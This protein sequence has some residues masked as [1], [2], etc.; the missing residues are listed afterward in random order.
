MEQDHLAAMLPTNG[1]GP[2]TSSAS[3]LL[4]KK[5]PPATTTPRVDLER[6]LPTIMNDLVPL[7]VIV[8]RVVSQAYADLANLAETLPSSPD[9]DR[10]RAIVDYV[11]QT[12]RQILK[13]LVLVRWSG[14]ASNVGK[15]MNIIGFLGRQNF[16]FDS[17][18]ASLTDAKSSLSS[19]R[20]RNYDIPTA[21]SVLTSGTY[22]RLPGV[23]E[24]E[25]GR[26]K[27]L[28]DEE[29]LKVLGETDEVLRWRLGVK[30]VLPRGMRDYWIAD[31]RATFVVSGVW[32]ASFTYASNTTSQVSTDDEEEGEWF[33]LSLRFLFKV[34]DARGKRLALSYQLEALHS[35]AQVLAATTWASALKVEWAIDG[36]NSGK[37]E[38]RIA[39]WLAFEACLGGTGEEVQRKLDVS[40]SAE[41]LDEPEKKRVKLDFLYHQLLNE[42]KS[43]DVE[44]INESSIEGGE[45]VAD[46]TPTDTGDIT[47][48]VKVPSIRV[49][50]FGQHQ[51]IA[52]VSSLSG[53]LE[54]KAVGEVAAMREAR[55]RNAAEKVDKDRKIAGETLLRVRAS[56]IVDEV[57]SRAAYLGFRTVRRLSLRSHDLAKFGMGTR[58]FLFIHLPNLSTHYLVLVLQE[59][60]FR[61]ALI[62]VSEV[63]DGMQ[64]WLRVD[65]L[66]W[67]DKSTS[68]GDWGA[69]ASP[70]SPAGEKPAAFGHDVSIEDLR[71]VHQYCVRRIAFFKLE[72]QLHVRR[73]PFKAVSSAPA[74]APADSTLAKRSSSPSFTQP[75]L[76]SRSSPYLVIQSTDLLRS[77]AKVA[78]PNIAIQCFQTDDDQL[79]TTIH[80]RFKDLALVNPD[81]AELPSSM[82]YDPRTS[83]ITFTSN[84]ID[85][86]I[87]NFLTAYSVV[88][89]SIVLAQH[90]AAEAGKGKKEEKEE[91]GM[92]G[93]AVIP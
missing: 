13:L 59:E 52:S 25:F 43:E 33:L 38:V 18:I 16:A 7:S 80:V 60:G 4:V 87:P 14:E 72:Q 41:G 58:S 29:A 12:R 65:E 1:A 49:H 74:S 68:T 15:C 73:I 75:C 42:L 39:Y 26:D 30:E 10:K 24:E 92:T 40:W 46:S 63:S 5:E 8:E 83:V 45:S 86:C 55:L 64:T 82:T 9:P 21:L 35:Q 17:T 70:S 53:R 62:Q 81:P 56:T 48:P 61:F 19:A 90:R 34:M 31:G 76:L 93:V 67:L 47:T 57:D 23:L 66:G 84:D 69:A 28:S 54:F 44:L 85:T 78:Y 27:A 71:D 11:L 91:E 32:E 22:T 77:T 2:S 36:E 88:A 6:E 50:L 79:K 37:K 20:V 51:V 89:R 3:P